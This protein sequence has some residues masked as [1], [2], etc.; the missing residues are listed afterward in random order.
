MKADFEFLV[1]A[2]V[3]ALVG[4]V[5]W[6]IILLLAGRHRAF[7]QASI[8]AYD[9]SKW[10]DQVPAEEIPDAPEL[11]KILVAVF[12]NREIPD[13]KIRNL[14]FLLLTLRYP[15][16]EIATADRLLK[17]MTDLNPSSEQFGLIREL[18]FWIEERE[19]ECQ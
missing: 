17:I 14:E 16:L 5:V 11:R 2:G 9:I 13:Q 18:K 8:K 3:A 10:S 19:L 7:C 1:A 4:L 12:L 6:K 15:F